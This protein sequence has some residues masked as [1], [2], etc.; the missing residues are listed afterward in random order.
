MKIQYRL[1]IFL[2]CLVLLNR[3][4][5]LRVSFA[6]VAHS[7]KVQVIAMQIVKIKLKL[8]NYVLVLSLSRL[9]CYAEK[10]YL[11]ALLFLHNKF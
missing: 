4:F 2:L 5:G 3:A 9:P 11:P 8:K 1:T 10:K 6:F 7:C